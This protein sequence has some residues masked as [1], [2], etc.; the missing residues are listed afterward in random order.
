MIFDC[1]VFVWLLFFKGGK[2][3]SW[4]NSFDLFYLLNIISLFT[5]LNN[6]HTWVVVSL[7]SPPP[8]KKNLYE[9][10]WMGWYI[11]MM[12][13]PITCP[14]QLWPFSSFFILQLAEVVWCCTV[15]CLACRGRTHSGQY[16]HDQKKKKEK[17]QHDLIQILP[18][19]VWT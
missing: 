2:R 11:V 14:P 19:L 16:L 9:T 12:K 15:Y 13:L 4:I 10:W 3:K 6:F 17:C 7:V 18:H 8:Q 1:H 5:S